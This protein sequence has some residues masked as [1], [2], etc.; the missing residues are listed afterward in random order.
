MASRLVA[1]I[2]VFSVTPSVDVASTT[3]WSFLTKRRRA[4]L[5]CVPLSDEQRE[6]LADRIWAYRGFSDQE[7]TQ[8]EN[9]VK[10]MIGERRWEGHGDLQVTEE[11]QLTI[12]GKA[13]LMLLGAKDYYFSSVTTILVHPV[14][15]ERSRNGR[16]TRSVGEAW[17]C[18][19]V[20]LSWPEVV[21]DGRDRDGENVVI[22]EF[23]HHLDGLDG[24]M[25]GSIPFPSR[26]DEQRW[27]IVATREFERLVADVRQG[28]STLF[29]EYGAHSLAEFF[30]VASECFFEKPV[31]MQRRYSDLFEL[32]QMFYRVNPL[33]WCGSP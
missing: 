29:D 21:A 30:A 33:A 31:E 13:S 19:G 10:V 20:L 28:N 9:C 7:R 17:Q 12:A 32:M 2:L 16:T 3:I 26:A 1:Y 15:I 22:H 5:L 25:G 6:L 18:G 27:C 14:V 23:A 4:R 8:F 24:E 11:M